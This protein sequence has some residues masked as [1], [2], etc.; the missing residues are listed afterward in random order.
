MG[1]FA[2]AIIAAIFVV[3]EAN[4]LRWKRVRNPSNPPSPADRL[5]N[6]G[7]YPLYIRY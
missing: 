3:L 1:S 5:A 4:R 7:A 2:W 6:K